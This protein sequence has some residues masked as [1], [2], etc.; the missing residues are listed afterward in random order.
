MM[1]AF[2]L[3][4]LISLPGCVPESGHHAYDYQALQAFNFGAAM[5]FVGGAVFGTA[6]TL[7]WKHFSAKK[8]TKDGE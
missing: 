8:R 2:V 6:G 4:L 1:R 3:L 7:A 5:G